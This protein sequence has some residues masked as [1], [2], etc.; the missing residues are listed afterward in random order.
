MGDQRWVVGVD[1][2]AIYMLA[3]K[4]KHCMHLSSVKLAFQWFGG[5]CS[6][7]NE[8]LNLVKLMRKLHVAKTVVN[9]I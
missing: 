7:K 3:L 9:V 2:R 5:C 4:L 6:E 8:F 1:T